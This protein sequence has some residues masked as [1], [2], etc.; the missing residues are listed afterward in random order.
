MCRRRGERYPR[1]AN[2]KRRSYFVTFLPPSQAGKVYQKQFISRAR[3]FPPHGCMR[4]DLRREAHAAALRESRT[5][6][7]TS[8]YG[9]GQ[10]FPGIGEPLKVLCMSIIDRSRK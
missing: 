8:L 3:E 7:Y 4:R 10:I 5:R 2:L 1:A 9:I 6:G